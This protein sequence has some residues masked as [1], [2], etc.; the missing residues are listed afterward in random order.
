MKIFSVDN[1]KNNKHNIYCLFGV[2]IKLRKD[3]IKSKISPL[4]YG[5][6]IAPMCISFGRMNSMNILN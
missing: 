5:G 6:G 2:K 1:N 3:F 4:I